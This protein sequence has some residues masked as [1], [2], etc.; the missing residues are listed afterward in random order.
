MITP[1]ETRIDHV[2]EFISDVSDGIYV[3]A[4]PITDPFGPSIIEEDLECCVV[5]KETIRGGNAINEKRVAKG[6]S[7]LDIFEIGL[8]EGE[9]KILSETKLSSSAIRRSKLGKLLKETSKPVIDFGGKY[10]IGLTGGICSGKTHISKFLASKG[11]F[12][13][14][15]STINSAFYLFFCLDH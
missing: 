12:V 14:L 2:K 6:L 11:C 9:D 15:L 10:V 1:C 13:S 3:N 7:H 5:S 8:L 4:V